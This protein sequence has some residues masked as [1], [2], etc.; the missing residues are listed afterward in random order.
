LGPKL[1]LVVLL[2]QLRNLRAQFRFGL[3]AYSHSSMWMRSCGM[4][5]V[6]RSERNER[7]M[8]GGPER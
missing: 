5:A 1:H 7:I 6:A 2:H 3:H 8:A 4:P